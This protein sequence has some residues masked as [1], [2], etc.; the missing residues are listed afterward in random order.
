MTMQK[1]LGA[2]RPLSGFGLLMLLALSA[3]PAPSHAQSADQVLCDRIAADPAD[4]DKPADVKGVTTV[5]PSDVPIALKYCKAAASKS[6]RAVYQL[7]RAYA[8]N[9]QMAEAIKL[10]RQAIAKGSTGAMVELG[11]LLGTGTGVAKNPDEARQLFER[12]AKAGNARGATNLAALQGGAAAANPA[13]ARALYARAA[14]GNSAEAQYQLGLLDAQGIGG[15]KD[16]AAA[17]SL[18]EKAAA[19]GHADA[20]MWAG[21]F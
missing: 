20:N 16:D 2:L 15:A 13:E 19:Q 7:G 12:A 21:A 4:P 8:A 17:R 6:R 11:V 1:S 5:A 18:F 9:R 10:Y 14:D 3:M